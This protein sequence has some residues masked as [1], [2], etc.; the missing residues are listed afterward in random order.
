ML[1]HAMPITH[2]CDDVTN[3]FLGNVAFDFMEFPFSFRGTC[4]RCGGE[5]FI[6]HMPSEEDLRAVEPPWVAELEEEYR[7]KR[8]EEK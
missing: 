6:Q 1:D 2:Q 7:E 3:Q 4:P 8:E 5:I